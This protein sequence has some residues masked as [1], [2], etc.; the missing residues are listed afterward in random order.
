[1]LTQQYVYKHTPP[2]QHGGSPQPTPAVYVRR[3]LLI[4]KPLVHLY[5]TLLCSMLIWENISSVFGHV[6]IAARRRN[7]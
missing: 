6:G 1:M 2:E 5:T 7:M 4:P 3:G